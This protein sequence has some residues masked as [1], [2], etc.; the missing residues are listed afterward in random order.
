MAQIPLTNRNLYLTS[1][2]GVWVLAQIECLALRFEHRIGGIE[3]RLTHPLGLVAMWCERALLW[4]INHVQCAEQIFNAIR[5]LIASNEP[6]PI[7]QLRGPNDDDALN[8]LAWWLDYLVEWGED[9]YILPPSQY[10]DA[11]MLDVLAASRRLAE[12]NPSCSLKKAARAY[13]QSGD[14]ILDVVEEIIHSRNE[15]ETG[16]EVDS[17]AMSDLESQ[18]SS[19]SEPK[20]DSGIELQNIPESER[21]SDSETQEW[22]DA[23]E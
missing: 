16:S 11:K 7:D 18:I 21:D 22:A 2:S 10:G 3:E 17:E 12:Q 8:E 14:S 23:E 20:L 1:C 15:P 19:E 6:V 4:L 13:L 9:V 5:T